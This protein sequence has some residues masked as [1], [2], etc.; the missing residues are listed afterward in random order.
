M[1]TGVPLKRLEKDEA[2][3]LLGLEAELHKTVVSQN[4]AISAIARTS[5]ARLPAI[6][7]IT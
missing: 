1:M 4:E 3:R 6:L 7:F 5:L 2:Q